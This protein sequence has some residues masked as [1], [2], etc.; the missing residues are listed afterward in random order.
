MASADIPTTTVIRIKR[1]R[2]EDPI[3]ALV[4]SSDAKKKKT[5]E[6]LGTETPNL[7]TFAGTIE[8]KENTG[9]LID[10]FKQGNLK[11][12]KTNK[13]AK[14]QRRQT[15]KDKIKAARFTVVSNKREISDSLADDIHLVDAI[16]T[17]EDF[18]QNDD[19]EALFCN[20]VKMIR[21]KLK[22][23][24]GKRCEE[25]DFVYDLYFAPSNTIILNAD[26]EILQLE[27]YFEQIYV[28]DEH[29]GDSEEFYD[30]EDDENAEE[31]WRNDYP[32]ED[33]YGSSEH[34]RD[35]FESDEEE[36]DFYS[37]NMYRKGKGR[38]AFDPYAREDMNDYYNA[39][40]ASDRDSD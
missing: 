12:S 4:I 20:S 17:E 7:F 37:N 6:D 30:D 8:E 14:N 23:D 22:I 36:D 10:K 35:S 29:L 9:V 2:Q 24:D 5:D 13:N 1:K 31:N 32:D 3:N 28:E 26:S 11:I 40:S 38:L 19:E 27:E 15:A 16:A 39:L 18:P 33:E 25:E 34:E 21:E